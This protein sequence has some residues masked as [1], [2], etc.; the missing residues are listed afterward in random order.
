[1]ETPKA[2]RAFLGSVWANSCVAEEGACELE[3]TGEEPSQTAPKHGFIPKGTF[4]ESKSP[5]DEC[6]RPIWRMLDLPGNEEWEKDPLGFSV[7]ILST[8]SPQ[9]HQVTDRLSPFF[10]KVFPAP[11]SLDCDDITVLCLAGGVKP[12]AQQKTRCSALREHLLLG[13]GWGS[14]SSFQ[15]P[16]QGAPSLARPPHMQS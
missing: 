15:A 5:T 4:S 7:G 6:K 16:A 11:A 3:R 8:R 12:C 1:M 9:P 2:G 14:S 10:P 13:L